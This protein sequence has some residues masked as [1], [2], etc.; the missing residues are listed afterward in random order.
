M[1]VSITG[2]H[3]TG[4]DAVVLF[5]EEIEA[6][7]SWKIGTIWDGEEFAVTELDPSEVHEFV[8]YIRDRVI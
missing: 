4:S 6:D 7:M 5:A 3:Q 8:T 2:K 1:R